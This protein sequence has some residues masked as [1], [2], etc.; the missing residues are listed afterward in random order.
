MYGP[1]RF[2]WPDGKIGVSMRQKHLFDRFNIQRASTELPHLRC[3]VRVEEEEHFGCPAERLHI[4]QSA[5]SLLR[6][7]LHRAFLRVSSVA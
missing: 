2:R 3:F 5:P 4:A 6:D 7:Y 1:S